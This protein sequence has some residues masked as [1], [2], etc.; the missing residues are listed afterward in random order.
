M[1]FSGKQGDE[2]HAR[3]KDQLVLI[4]E[5]MHKARVEFWELKVITI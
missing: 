1:D 5:C 2:K 3:Q 4:H